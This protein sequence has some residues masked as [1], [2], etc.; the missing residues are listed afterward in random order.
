MKRALWRYGL[1]VACTA[2]ALGLRVLLD[3]VLGS[4]I[5]YATFY[6]AVMV[7]AVVGGALPGM[8]ATFLG[9]WAAA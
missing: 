8:I 2:A 1:P 5:P 4:R 7:S 6:V 9:A 3:P